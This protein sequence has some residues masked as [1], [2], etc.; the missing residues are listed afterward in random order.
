MEISIYNY[1][2]MFLCKKKRK[3]TNFLDDIIVL[4]FFIHK[5]TAFQNSFVL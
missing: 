3:K 1:F 5:N 2:Y 4:L